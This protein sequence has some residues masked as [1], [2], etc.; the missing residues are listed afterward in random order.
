MIEF[1]AILRA[2]WARDRRLDGRKVKLDNL[3]IVDLTRSWYPEHPL[4]RVVVPDRLD[5]SI[6]SARVP[7]IIERLFV[8]SEEAH[9]RAV[10]RGHIR[11]GRSI[12]GIQSSGT[13]AE[14][15]YELTD[16]IRLSEHFRHSQHKVGRCRARRKLT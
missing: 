7:H 4:G 1:D 13:F 2:L 11:Y 9:R 8:N 15:L 16:N 12:G 6:D 14:I 5:L 3:R 10:F